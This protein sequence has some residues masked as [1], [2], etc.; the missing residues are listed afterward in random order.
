RIVFMMTYENTPMDMETPPDWGKKISH[1]TFALDNWMLSGSDVPP[2]RYQRPQGFALQ[3]NLTDP[4]ESERIYQSLK[5][6]GK[7]EMPLQETFWA[8]RFGVLIDQFG[9]SWLINCEKQA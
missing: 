1:A 8:L 7:V 2:A 9:I 6:N 4:L 5:E 3:L